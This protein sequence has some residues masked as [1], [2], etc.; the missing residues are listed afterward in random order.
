[1]Y[2]PAYLVVNMGVKSH[3]DMHKYSWGWLVLVKMKARPV[4]KYTDSGMTEIP[5]QDRW[6]RD[7]KEMASATKLDTSDNTKAI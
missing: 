2:F 5:V 6:A 7:V 3:S 4:I 1:M